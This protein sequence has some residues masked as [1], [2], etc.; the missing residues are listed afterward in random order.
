MP[1]LIAS[2]CVAS[3]ALA[4]F[5]LY[6]CL[7]VRPRVK[8]TVDS[9]LLCSYAHRGLHGG[10]IPENSLAAFERACL[11]GHG[12]ELDV[13]LSRDGV[14]TVFHDYTLTR[15]T[16]RAEKLCELDSSELSTLS[17]N[18]TAEHIPTFAEVLTL[19]AGRVP[20]LVELKG[21][22]TNTELCK[23]VAEQLKAYSGKYCIES[24][25][26]LLVREIQ[27]HLPSAF[28][29][30]LYTNVC[31]EKKKATPLAVLL[32]LM[33]FNFLAKP[34]FVAYDGR[35]RKSLPVKLATGLYRAP[36]F[37][38]TVRGKAELEIARANG[39]CPIFEE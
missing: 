39:E 37:V 9:E 19:V 11:A 32:T 1:F 13:Q 36:R 8:K 12:I 17:L 16:G 33:A 26:P 18:N 24:F 3:V 29:G 28:C 30:L 2:I 5:L 23:S 31:R 35:L 20:I 25:N 4:L 14:V 6:I 15:M 27:K 7:F 38:W 34:A 10:G 21:E 22:T